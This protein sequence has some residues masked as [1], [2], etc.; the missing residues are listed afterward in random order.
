[1]N[2]QDTSFFS[3]LKTFSR[4]ETPLMRLF[5]QRTCRSACQSVMSKPQWKFIEFR[6]LKFSWAL[7]VLLSIASNHI[8]VDRT[9]IEHHLFVQLRC[10]N[11]D[12]G[13][14]TSTINLI[15]YSRLHHSSLWG[16]LRMLSDYR[17]SQMDA[18]ET[19]CASWVLHFARLWRRI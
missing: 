18:L 14:M 10:H 8:A 5:M 7:S 4:C 12:A 16:M 1:M 2:F 15:Q 6:P 19:S 17:T 11:C 9:S 13:R 3:F